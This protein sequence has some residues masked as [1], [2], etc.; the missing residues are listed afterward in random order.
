M[1]FSGCVWHVEK[2][3]VSAS[4][5]IYSQDESDP[6]WFDSLVIRHLDYGVIKYTAFYINDELRSYNGAEK[7]MWWIS[8]WTH[9]SKEGLICKYVHS[10]RPSS[11]G[12]VKHQ[13]ATRCLKP[14]RGGASKPVSI[15]ARISNPTNG[16][17]GIVIIFS[18]TMWFWKSK[19][20]NY[21]NDKLNRCKRWWKRT[22]GWRRLVVWDAVRY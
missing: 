11:F 9:W 12:H 21:L 6:I 15:T 18:V 16:T 1:D 5:L 19:Q 14:P 10:V 3:L 13:Y 2:N 22:C 4:V 8:V 17:N 7:N 20:V